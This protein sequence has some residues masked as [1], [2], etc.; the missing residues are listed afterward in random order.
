[1]SNL[2]GFFFQFLVASF[3]TLY[4]QLHEVY[5]LYLK[6]VSEQEKSGKFRA[7]ERNDVSQ[8]AGKNPLRSTYNE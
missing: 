6:K 3:L 2:Q 4:L 1:M 5:G 8:R 7:V